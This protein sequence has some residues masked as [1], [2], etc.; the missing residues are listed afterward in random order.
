M[1]KGRDIVLKIKFL[2]DFAFVSESKRQKD[3]LCEPEDPEFQK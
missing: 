1:G 3:S 2:L